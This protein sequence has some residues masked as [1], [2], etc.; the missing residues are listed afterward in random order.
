MF[1]NAPLDPQCDVDQ[2]EYIGAAAGEQN[3]VDDGNGGDTSQQEEYGPE[4]N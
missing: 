2:V 1:E 4:Y 3:W